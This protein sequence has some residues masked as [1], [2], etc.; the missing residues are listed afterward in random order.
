MMAVYVCRYIVRDAP[1]VST[2]IY[3]TQVCS[4]FLKDLQIQVPIC[5][6]SARAIK[7]VHGFG[8]IVLLGPYGNQD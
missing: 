2:H 4:R 7:S 3:P 6:D 5:E 8:Y 1:W